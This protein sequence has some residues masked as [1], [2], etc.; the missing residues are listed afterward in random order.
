MLNLA[1]RHEHIY[2]RLETHKMWVVNFTLRPP[3]SQGNSSRY[4]LR[5]WLD[6]RQNLSG[7]CQEGKKILLYTIESRIFG[8][9]IH[10]LVTMLPEPPRLPAHSLSVVLTWVE[11]SHSDSRKS[12][13]KYV[14]YFIVLDLRTI[15]YNLIW[16]TVQNG[17]NQ[18]DALTPL[19][20][21][22]S[23][24]LAR[25]KKIK[26]ENII[27]W[28]MAPRNPVVNWSFEAR[29]C[30]YLQGLRVNKTIGDNQV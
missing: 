22:F 17:P 19:L 25:S 13:T 14:T 9:P 23:L 11:Y 4:P 1:P 20:F 21:K 24:P 6:G 29:Y 26:R 15:I 10:S 28:D 7:G 5:K 16:F 2:V 8:R 30:L 12:R 27:I 3:Y 18:G